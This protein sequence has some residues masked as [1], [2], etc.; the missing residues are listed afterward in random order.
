[1]LV[2]NSFAVIL[3]LLVTHVISQHLT[4]VPGEEV[5]DHDV[6]SH[7]H[8]STSSHSEEFVATH[9]WQEIKEG[10]SIPKGLHVRVNLQTGLK[11]AKLLRSEGDDSN[12][13]SDTN[14]GVKMTFAESTDN[15]KHPATK[16]GISAALEEALKNIATSQDEPSGNKEFSS[17]PNVNKQTFKSIDEIKEVFS[18]GNITLSSEM[19][20]LSNLLKELTISVDD[21]NKPFQP[22]LDDI[23]F[24]LHNLDNAVYFTDIGGVDVIS[25][26]VNTSSDTSLVAKCAL[27]LG[28]ACQ[29][30]V[31]VTKAARK[32][33]P[34]LLRRLQLAANDEVH[35]AHQVTEHTLFA[36]SSMV[37]TD[38]RTIS[39]LIS[40]GAG[41]IFSNIV[42]SHGIFS[43][44]SK[45]KVYTLFSDLLSNGSDED[46]ELLSVLLRQSDLT[47]GL[48]HS[49]STSL[50]QASKVSDVEK[51][52]NFLQ[53]SLAYNKCNGLPFDLEYALISVQQKYT[54]DINDP[55]IG[56]YLKEII[57]KVSVLQSVVRQTRSLHNTDEL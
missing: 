32:V 48:C 18:K 17:Q 24:Y 38:H 1:M 56:D 31:Y 14:H 30:N 12:A 29:S 36:I 35:R 23:E 2:H 45:V 41:A 8:F 28:V 11:E 26:L 40:H 25:N 4:T 53:V 39:D 9:E 3:I 52:L 37:R 42:T 27:V 50:V 6:A 57:E 16:R 47:A 51:L 49:L 34:A 5:E 15:D 46:N 7:S 21:L 44:K 43:I 20:I 33:I 54:E 10:Q 19:E 13:A 55:A 22:I